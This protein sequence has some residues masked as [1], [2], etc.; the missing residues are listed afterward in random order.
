MDDQKVKT[1]HYRQRQFRIG[2]PVKFDN[3]RYVV[4]GGSVN[5][6]RL[7]VT[8]KSGCGGHVIE[9]EAKNFPKI[10]L[11]QRDSRGLLLTAGLQTK[12]R[13]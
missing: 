8:Q 6:L 13:R 10:E 12:R 3:R 4:V 11:I 2:D 9:V 7:Q 5:V 1:E